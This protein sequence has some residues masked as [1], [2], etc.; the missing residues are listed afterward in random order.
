MDRIKIVVTDYIEP[1]LEW[2]EQELAGYAPVVF[3]HYQLKFAP[4][5]E[6]IAKIRDADVI[7][8]NM[9]PMTAEVIESLE[10]CK[11][12]VRH[13]VGYDNVDLGAATRRGIRVG[14]VPDY[15]TE[16]VAEQAIMLILACSRK[17]FIGRSVL[18]ESSRKGLWDFER[19]YPVF[20]LQG[21]ILGIVGCGRI[22]S[23]VLQ[24][25]AGFAFDLRV[26]DPYLPDERKQELG[27]ETVDLETT[28]R[29]SDIV[30]LHAPLNDETR[31]MINEPQLRMM[32]NTAYLINTA[33]GPLVHTQALIRAL[34]E[35]WIAGAGIDVYE[36]E[37][38]DLDSELFQLENATLAP[39]LA[40]Y[41]EEAGWSIR[42]KIMEDF[43]RFMNGQPP[44]FLVN[45]EVEEVLKTSRD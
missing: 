18:E 9:A 21:K 41:S 32:K 25:M 24:K 12:I 2:E 11:L 8:V 27:I 13:G 6:L 4:R 3:E 34:K 16:E 38:P 44:R 19:C 31:S 43:V 28:L 33:R 14:N 1:D 22:G 39:H 7:L 10:R 36:K 35:K 15:C 5:E 45:P 37:P 23:R 29:E 40:W 26:C 42:E 20:Q 30:T 17:A